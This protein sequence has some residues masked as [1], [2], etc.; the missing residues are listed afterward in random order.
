MQAVDSV[1]SDTLA[2]AA[3]RQL[4]RLAERSRAILDPNV[5]QVRAFLAEHE[6]W[7]D[8]VVPARSMT[9]FPRLRKEADSEPL[10]DWL[11]GRETSIVPGKFFEAPRHFRLGFAVMPEDVALGLEILSEGLRRVG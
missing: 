4:P 6:D 9:V 3:F 1:P 7:L 5:A 2:V 10:H 8:C 11:R